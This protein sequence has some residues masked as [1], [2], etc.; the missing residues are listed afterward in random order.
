MNS[1]TKRLV[2]TALFIALGTIVPQAFHMLGLGPSQVFLPMHLPVMICCSLLGPIAGLICGLIT[3][4]LSSVL[5]GMP[6]LMPVGLAMAVELGTYGLVIGYLIKK[7]NI[8]IAL[9]V[10]MLAGRL[11]NGIVNALIAGFSASAFGI[12]AYLT[13]VFVTALPGLVIQLI[14]VPLC[15]KLLV[16]TRLFE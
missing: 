16:K 14:L 11:V 9:I 7:S 8:W 2:M 4:L 6:P 12:T 15:Y 5:T 10:S 1:K 3:P 13:T